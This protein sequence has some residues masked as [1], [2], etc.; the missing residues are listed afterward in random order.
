M[1]I[2]LVILLVKKV[3]YSLLLPHVL[4]QAKEFVKIE[5]LILRLRETERKSETEGDLEKIIKRNLS[6]NWTTVH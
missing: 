1:G 3:Y 4:Y 6:I 2:G 5:L